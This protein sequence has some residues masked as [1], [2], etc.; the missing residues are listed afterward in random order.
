MAWRD[1][2]GPQDGSGLYTE[3]R[4]FLEVLGWDVEFEIWRAFKHLF[5]S[6]PYAEY[7]HD[8]I[9]SN[10][11]PGLYHVS[12]HECHMALD[13]AQT[14]DRYTGEAS[15][16]WCRCMQ[17]GKL[18]PPSFLKEAYTCLDIQNSDGK[19]F[20]GQRGLGHPVTYTQNILKQHKASRIG[21]T[22]MFNDKGT[23]TTKPP[24][25]GVEK[26]IVVP[27]GGS[28][29]EEESELVQK[30][31]AIQAKVVRLHERM[32]KK[33]K[34]EEENA[35][36]RKEANAKTVEKAAKASVVPV[37]SA[38][39]EKADRMRA[40]VAKAE[41]QLEVARK[42]S[43]REK[44]QKQGGVQN[45]PEQTVVARTAPA[46]MQDAVVVPT[47]MEI[48]E[49]ERNRRMNGEA[50]RDDEVARV[51]KEIATKTKARAQGPR[52]RV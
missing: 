25:G 16:L 48:K 40:M 20:C 34:A 26:G 38:V 28:M 14:G 35:A 24:L 3:T 36:R 33:S 45:R 29:S 42:A 39:E 21:D 11:P 43:G 23:S 4:G 9:T 46:V 52:L 18:A 44:A 30:S 19:L 13:T 49:K 37:R 10:G 7:V 27:K 6:K 15:V 2:A 50:S 12:C 17:G 5:D 1:R 8:L 22:A 41:A 32:A 47:L 51:F 31:D